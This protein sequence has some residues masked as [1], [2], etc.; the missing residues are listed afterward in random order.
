MDHLKTLKEAEIIVQI[1]SE[2]GAEYILLLCNPEMST[3]YP[4]WLI[5]R[6]V[7][8]Y[9]EEEVNNTQAIHYLEVLKK[10]HP[11]QIALLETEFE[12]S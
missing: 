11:S 2:T 9:N 10:S 12:E 6:I 1:N 4:E 3:V 5:Q 8:L 7:D